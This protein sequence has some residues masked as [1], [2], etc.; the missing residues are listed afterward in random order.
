MFLDKVVRE[1][2]IWIKQEW[3]VQI[4]ELIIVAEKAL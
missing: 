1:S 2:F 4:R 3:A